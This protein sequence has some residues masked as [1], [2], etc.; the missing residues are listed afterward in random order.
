MSNSVPLLKFGHGNAKLNKKIATFSLPSGITCPFAKDC[1]CF[2]KELPNNKLKVMQDKDSKFRC[3]SASLEAVFPSLFK[4]TRYNF[5]LLNKSSNMQ[6]LIEDSLLN[7]KEDYVRI[8]VSGDFFNEKYFKAWI[9]AIK[10]SP[11][12][13]YAYTK[14]IK[15]W[16]KNKDLMPSN[17]ELI[18]SF[19]GKDDSLIESNDLKYVKV[20]FNPDDAKKDGVEIDHDDHLALDPKV[21]RFGLLLHGMQQ[22]E[23]DASK[24]LKKMKEA[25]VKF[26]YGPKS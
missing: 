2:V 24:A 13:F 15:Y 7:V 18:A 11:K 1:K 19:G 21:K 16:V 26:A 3:Y 8:H 6:K 23:S 5:D 22:K 25:G 12:H 14:S 20:Y 9:G 17:L 4:L 10:N